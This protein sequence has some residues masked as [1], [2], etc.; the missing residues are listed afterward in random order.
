MTLY[1]REDSNLQ[2]PMFEI[3]GFAS[4]PTTAHRSEMVNPSLT[5]VGFSIYF[6]TSSVPSGKILSTTPSRA[7]TT[8]PK[9]NARV[10]AAAN[11]AV[12][13]FSIMAK[14]GVEPSRPEGQQLLK[15]PRIPV[16]P[17]GRPNIFLPA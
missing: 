11:A 17:H 12:I 5:L 7:I 3:G 10:W 16:S 13:L 1:G 4:L 15:L 8:G 9:D 14:E 6:N 2:T